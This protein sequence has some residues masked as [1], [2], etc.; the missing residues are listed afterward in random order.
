MQLDKLWKNHGYLKRQYFVFHGSEESF[1][2]C[3][4]IARK[5]SIYKIFI[6]SILAI[7]TDCKSIKV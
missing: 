5:Q 1:D 3:T 4:N 6:R 7:I 2:K